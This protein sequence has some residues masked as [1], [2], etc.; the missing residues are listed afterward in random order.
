[1]MRDQC[2]VLGNGPS[3]ARVP[4][5]VLDSLPTFGSNRIFKKYVPNFYCCINPTE[6]NKYPVE[7]E[8]MNCE[9][10]FV[11]DKVKIPGVTPLHSTMEVDFSI[12]P[13]WAVNEGY[14]VTF[15]LLQLA[16]FYGFR[17]VFLLGVDHRYAQPCKPNA[18]ITWHG[19][20]VNHFADDYVKPGEH[21]N[22]ADLRHSE[23]YFQKAKEIFEM[24]GRRIVNLTEG[25]ALDVFER[26][27]L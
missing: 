19:K 17:E 1:M 22:C 5:L 3:L 6:A 20:D 16:F 24:N 2:Y 9:Y 14:S 27:V 15:V 25:S 8:V 11:T 10:K 12:N 7:I 23:I 13:F 18:E 4:N 26:G 21:W